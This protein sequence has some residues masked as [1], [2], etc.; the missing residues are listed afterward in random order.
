MG[1]WGFRAGW[2]KG[3][4]DCILYKVFQQKNENYWGILKTKKTTIWLPM[5][6]AI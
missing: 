1:K 3:N 6:N 4:N 2:G 5:N